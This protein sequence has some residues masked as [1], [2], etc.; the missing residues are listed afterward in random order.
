MGFLSLGSCVVAS[1]TRLAYSVKYERLSIEANY[2]DGNFAV[3][4][5]SALLHLKETLF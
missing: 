5:D 3:N 2:E 1:I 4:F